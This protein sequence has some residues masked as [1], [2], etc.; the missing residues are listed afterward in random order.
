[1]GSGIAWPVPRLSRCRTTLGI[2]SAL[3]RWRTR[4]SVG[5]TPLH[6]A[7]TPGVIPPFRSRRPPRRPPPDPHRPPNKRGSDPHRD[8]RP[9][10][11]VRRTLQRSPRFTTHC[12][13]G[14]TAGG[15]V[16]DWVGGVSCSPWFHAVTSRIDYSVSTSEGWVSGGGP[17]QAH[18]LRG[19]HLGWGGATP[20]GAGTH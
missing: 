1:M 5:A 10:F 12:E 18:D 3:W 8:P 4:Y 16:L 9:V 2:V 6:Y 15:T 20:G 14:A 7:S 19:H 13:A 17:T 11:G